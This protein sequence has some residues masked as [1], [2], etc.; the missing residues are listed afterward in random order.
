MFDINGVN[1][2]VYKK[3]IEWC[4]EAVCQLYQVHLDKMIRK[5]DKLWGDFCRTRY[6][7]NDATQRYDEYL[8]LSTKGHD[9]R[10]PSTVIPMTEKT[11]IPEPEIHF[12]FF[13]HAHGDGN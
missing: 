9:K 13:N 10:N 4:S 6:V 5:D 2:S 7:W 1:G 12:S 3:F 8:G 11:V